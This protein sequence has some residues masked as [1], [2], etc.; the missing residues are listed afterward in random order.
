MK[1]QD[2]TEN[3]R[4]RAFL[5]FALTLLI[6]APLCLG[7]CVTASVMEY[8]KDK[9]SPSNVTAFA[10][11]KVHSASVLENGDLSILAEL[12]SP[13]HPKSGLYTMTIPIHPH[14]EDDAAMESFGFRTEYSPSFSGLTTYL[15][16]LG[17]AKKFSGNMD[18]K[19][20][21]PNSSVLI[22]ELNL[23]PDEAE[24]LPELL[25]RLNRDP[26]GEQKVYV[27][28]LLSGAAEKTGQEEADRATEERS[29]VEMGIL[30]VNWLP[31]T[32]DGIP[33]PIGIT[34]AYEDESTHLYYLLV[35]PAIA[36]DAFLIALAV[37]AQGASNG[38][39][40]MH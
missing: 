21:R 31:P 24:R 6:V 39:L 28:N 20:V 3:H 10:I 36:F 22:E 25:G 30:L 2:M 35:P 18:Q 26:S 13:N 8:A 37:V 11:A 14:M 34:G 15:F 12:D 5:L 9:A 7:G 32:S 17:K 33:R 29:T 19:N 27:V 1:T 40:N 4:S 23:H 16:P 38:Y